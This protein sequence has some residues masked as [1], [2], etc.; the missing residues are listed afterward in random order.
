MSSFYTC[1]NELSIEKRSFFPMNTKLQSKVS[2]VNS[3][4]KQNQIEKL[5]YIQCST[6]NI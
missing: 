6:F 4:K 3:F 5:F 1:C 2:L